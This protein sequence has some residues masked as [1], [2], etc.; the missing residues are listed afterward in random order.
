VFL[1]CSRQLLR[2]QTG[3]KVPGYSFTT[4][5]DGAASRGLSKYRDCG[6]VKPVKP[7]DF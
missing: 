4:G 7:K 6:S 5:V 2:L 3:F 1:A